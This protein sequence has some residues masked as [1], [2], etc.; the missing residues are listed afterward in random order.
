MRRCNIEYGD[1]TRVPTNK[2]WN[3]LKISFNIL[4]R[5][6]G[7]ETKMLQKLTADNKDTEGYE[8]EKRVSMYQISMWSRI[9]RRRCWLGERE[10][11]TRNEWTRDSCGGAILGAQRTLMVHWLLPS[12]CAAQEKGD[13]LR[14][15]KT[16]TALFFDPY[17]RLENT[18]P[19]RKRC[20]GIM[21]SAKNSKTRKARWK[22][23]MEGFVWVQIGAQ[24]VAVPDQKFLYSIWSNDTLKANLHVYL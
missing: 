9:F 3:P 19:I 24:Q 18:G 6:I 11:S 13:Q 16:I 1:L 20:R 12:A 14:R 8:F 10:R 22:R 7:K 21:K 5:G 23:K 2:I 15:Q 17:T 4:L